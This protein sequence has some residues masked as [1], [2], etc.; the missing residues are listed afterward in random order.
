MGLGSQESFLALLLLSYGDRS[1]VD[2]MVALDLL[3]AAELRGRQSRVSC[4]A[5]P[6]YPKMIYET[7]IAFRY[8]ELDG[9]TP[10]HVTFRNYSV[11][12][13]SRESGFCQSSGGP[14]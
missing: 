5:A 9:D 7:V 12:R 8:L 3:E 6:E 2:S 1:E 10:T 13:Q 11:D 14:A 4:P